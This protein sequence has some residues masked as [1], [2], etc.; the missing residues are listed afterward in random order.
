MMAYYGRNTDTKKWSSLVKVTTEK[1]PK[2]LLALDIELDSDQVE[3]GLDR[4][5][6]KLSQKVNVPGFR[7]GKAPRFILENYFGRPALIE[8]ATDDL[9]NKA[10]REALEQEKI[11]PVGPA[12]L[13]GAPNFDVEP[14]TFRVLV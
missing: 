9:V 11:E 3:K 5:A 12:S 13:D 4:A 1:L 6:R 8:E 7:K 10:F 2:S 14:Y